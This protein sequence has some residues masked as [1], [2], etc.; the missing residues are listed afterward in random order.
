ME[1]GT[2]V[3]LPNDPA[4]F[5]SKNSDENKDQIKCGTQI[6]PASMRHGFPA[7]HTSKKLCWNH[8]MSFK[9]EGQA[10]TEQ[11]TLRSLRPFG[12]PFGQL[13]VREKV[14]RNP[15]VLSSKILIIFLWHCFCVASSHY[16]SHYVP[17][18]SSST[19]SFWCGDLSILPHP[20]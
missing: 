7:M 17:Y 16:F 2:R 14:K 15:F 4:N 3:W 8:P 10:D 6:Q 12:K 5:S 1:N 19:I 11:H 13:T 20:I 18:E 9:I